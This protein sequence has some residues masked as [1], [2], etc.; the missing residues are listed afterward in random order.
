MSIWCVG[1]NYVEHAKELGNAIPEKPLFFLKSGHTLFRGPTM[2]Y[3]AGILS[4]HHELELAFRFDQHLRL[5][6]IALALDLTDRQRQTELKNKGEPWTLA[7]SFKNSCPISP[8]IPFDSNEN[9]SF[10]LHVNGQKKQ[11]GDM[12]LM[13]FKWPDLL[14]YLNLHFPV[15][16]ND[17]LLSGTPS[18]VGALNSGDVLKSL[19][20]NAKQQILIEWTLK[21][22]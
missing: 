3:P 9:Y 13:I 1:R 16:E 6:H 7:K 14:A 12:S 21:I 15:S 5:S 11:A 19:L 20:K 2:A 18:G 4:L 17:I 10:E 8:W 22:E